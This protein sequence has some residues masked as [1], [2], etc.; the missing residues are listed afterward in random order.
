MSLSA[1]FPFWMLGIMVVLFTPGPTNT[2][3]ASAGAARGLRPSL[4]LLLV[5]MLGY[6]MAVGM[7]GMLL[8]HLAGSLLHW[9]PNALRL[10]CAGYLI[11]LAVRLWLMP[12]ALTGQDVVTPGALFTAT[13]FNPKA[14]LF[15]SAIL[16]AAT[17]L[18][19]AD[20]AR[21][22]GL[23]MLLVVCIGWGWIALGH[24]LAN[25]RR[26]MISPAGLYRSAA[27]LLVLFAGLMIYQLSR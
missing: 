26:A 22:M 12:R 7:W 19:L 21:H 20:F 25:S 4:R 23:F 5:E 16:P 24:A 9:L 13:L 18:H 17:F 11:Y 8:H 15:A 10:V 27:V 3:L 6:V 14:F 1:S 2:L